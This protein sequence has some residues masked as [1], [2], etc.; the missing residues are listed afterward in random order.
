MHERN[1]VAAL[2]LV[3]EMGGDENCHAVVAREIDQRAP[4]RVARDRVDARGRLVEDEDGG[5]VQHRDREL[6]P[7]LDAER[8]AVRPRVDHGLQIVALEELFEPRRNLL[9]RQVIELSVQLEILPDRQFAVEREGLRHVADVAPRL[10]VARTHRLA[11]QLARAAARRQEAR[12]H[13]HRRRLAAAVGA[14]KAEDLAAG[15]SEADVIDRDEVAELPGQPFGLD[16]RRLIGRGD[17]GTHDDLLVQGPLGLRHQRDERLV[18]IGLAGL[19]QQL[20]QRAGRDDLGLVHRHQPVE[21]FGFVHV[22]GG[23]HHAHLR[24][25]GA[26]GVDQVPELAARQ[27]IDAGRRFVEDEKV[28]IVDQRAAK[29]Q[30]LLH[31]AG[32]L[33]G[34]PGLELLHGGCGQEL[35][36]AGSPFLR[37]LSEQAA[38]EIDVL[39]HAQ[40]RIRS[41]PSPCGI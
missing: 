31:A 13:L 25:A 26:D 9:R 4:E 36:D 29:A 8:Q 16:R 27:R 32:E 34:R 30:L 1:A 33:A 18:E 38:E 21:A 37:A 41:R 23:D 14:E 24:A 2:R 19:G 5:L 7:L 15:N 3:H 12:Q 40:R 10:H 6:K 39:E 28:W 11:E 35:G 20:L 22:G 17:A